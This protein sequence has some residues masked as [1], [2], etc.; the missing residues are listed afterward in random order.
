VPLLFLILLRS[1]LVI[2]VQPELHS[3]AISSNEPYPRSTS[4]ERRMIPWP[5]LQCVS[6]SE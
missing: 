6:C 2:R 5:G 1:T 3:A 4:R